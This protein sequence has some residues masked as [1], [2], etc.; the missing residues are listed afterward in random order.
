M[1]FW[2]ETTLKEEEAQGEGTSSK[3]AEEES[4]DGEI[5]EAMGI[6]GELPQQNSAPKLL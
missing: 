2:K 6:G 1:V 5:Q 4:H 3:R